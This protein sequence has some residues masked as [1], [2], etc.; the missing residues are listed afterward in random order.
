MRPL[1]RGLP[2]AA[3][4]TPALAEVCDTIRPGWDGT[5]VTALGEALA[6]LTSVPALALLVATALAF[7][8]RSQWGGLLVVLL[9]AGYGALLTMADSGAR[10][11]AMAEGCVGSPTLFLG[12]TAAI[13]VAMILY[14]A[15]LKSR[16]D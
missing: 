2:L 15:P 12:A 8:F 11:A 16:A 13:C 6:L 9:W 3:L 5:P 4:P 1:A 10:A 7:R 14:T